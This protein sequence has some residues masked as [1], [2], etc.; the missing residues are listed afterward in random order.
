L[1]WSRTGDPLTTVGSRCWEFS[2][3]YGRAWLPSRWKDAELPP[4]SP[5]PHI[6]EVNVGSDCRSYLS[7]SFPC[8]SG[9]I[10][11]ARFFF[12]NWSVTVRHLRF[13]VDRWSWRTPPPPRPRNAVELVLGIGASRCHL[14]GTDAKD[15]GPAGGAFVP[16]HALLCL[17]VIDLRFG[18]NG[19]W[20]VPQAKTDV[21]D[22]PPLLSRGP[23]SRGG[24]STA[25][26]ISFFCANSATFFESTSCCSPRCGGVVA[27]PRTPPRPTILSRLLLG[28]LFEE[29]QVGWTSD[30]RE[31][32]YAK[33]FVTTHVLRRSSTLQV[34]QLF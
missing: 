5:I 23:D 27:L 17:R 11:C 26:H 29:K 1:S 4:S 31:N 10:D 32:F 21:S 7:R 9:G 22:F 25:V 20:Q 24:W 3:C 30:P 18:E 34:G 14:T 16:F 12:S 28:L 15:S 8:G 6:R 2:C 33:F 19:V 13:F